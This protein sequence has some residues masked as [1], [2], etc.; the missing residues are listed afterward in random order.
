MKKIMITL[1]SSLVMTGSMAH[2]FTAYEVSCA[3]Q[4]RFQGEE[5]N[6]QIIRNSQVAVLT[7]GNT[8][9][10]NGVGTYQYQTQR[11]NSDIGTMIFQGD[12]FTLVVDEN[13]RQGHVQSVVQGRT[14]DMDN[15]VCDIQEMTPAPGVIMSNN[16]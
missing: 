8:S 16:R 6:V 2:A 9:M 1:T 13:T 11:Q 5:M 7:Y 10:A 12:N 3:P 4:M 15:L 14:L